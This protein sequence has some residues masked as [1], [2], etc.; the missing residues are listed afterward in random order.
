[1]EGERVLDYRVPGPGRMYRIYTFATD[2][3]AFRDREF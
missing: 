2:Y 3:P 1:M